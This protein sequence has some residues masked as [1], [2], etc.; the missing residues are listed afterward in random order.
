MT[1]WQ[2]AQLSITYSRVSTFIGQ[3]AKSS[4]LSSVFCSL[5]LC[6]FFVASLLHRRLKG[7]SQTYYWW[8]WHT[9]DSIFL[10]EHRL[11]EPD[12]SIGL[13]KTVKLKMPVVPGRSLL[14]LPCPIFPIHLRIRRLSSVTRPS[15]ELKWKW[16]MEIWRSILTNL[17]KY[18]LLIFGFVGTAPFQKY[19]WNQTFLD[20]TRLLEYS[21]VSTALASGRWWRASQV[22][23]FFEVSSAGYYDSMNLSTRETLG[24]KDEFVPYDLSSPPPDPKVYMLQ[25]F[26]HSC[27]YIRGLDGKLPDLPILKS[28]PKATWPTFFVWPNAD[29]TS[30]VLIVIV[31]RYCF[32]FYTITSKTPGTWVRLTTTHPSLESLLKVGTCQWSYRP[33]HLRQVQILH[34]PF[35]QFRY[36]H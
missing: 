9:I 16:R 35:Q 11:H 18:T 21:H 32:N 7:L 3:F 13:R 12:N 31:R 17:P 5:L 33:N 2:V 34:S 6:I 10:G 26:S 25:T 1:R 29:I 15:H 27:R 19:I 28:Y 4:W 24:V 30:H 22:T 8:R 14:Q 36:H 20:R 23:L